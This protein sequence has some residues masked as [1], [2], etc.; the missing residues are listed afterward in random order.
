MSFE[1][2]KP[3]VK[4]KEPGGFDLTPEETSDYIVVTIAG[5]KGDGKTTTALS[6]PGKIGAIT[7]DRKTSKIKKILKAENV[8][9]FNGVRYWSEDSGDTASIVKAGHT[10]YQY[11]H[12]LLNKFVNEQKYDWI[13]FDGLEELHLICEMNMRHGH[14]LGATEGFSQLTW[15]KERRMFLRSLHNRA[16]TAVKKGIIYTTYLTFVADKVENEKT[17]DGKKRPKWVDIILLE[18]DIVL[19]AYVK[20][21]TAG[22]K[23]HFV[24]VWSSKAPEFIKDGI[25][26]DVSNTNFKQLFSGEGEGP[27]EQAS[28]Q[29]S[30]ATESAKAVNTDFGGF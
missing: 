27:P 11:L 9:V 19:R 24:K 20:E 8:E 3:L 1:P 15:W 25:V 23:K 30:A 10:T 6:F 17:I 12:A 22:R 26:V 21:S 14:K 4:E 18:T 2:L 13:L 29:P 5:E 28:P 16:L 7:L